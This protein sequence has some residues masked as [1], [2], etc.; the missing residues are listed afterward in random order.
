[1][2]KSSSTTTT[3]SIYTL[4]VL[5]ISV[6]LVILRCRI[7]SRQLHELSVLDDINTNNKKL[8]QAQFQEL[9]NDTYTHAKKKKNDKHHYHDYAIFIVY[10][11]KTGCVLS[12]KLKKLINEVDVTAHLSTGENEVKQKGRR[13]ENKVLIKKFSNSAKFEVSG[14]DDT[15]ERVAFDTLGNWEHSSFPKRQHIEG[16]NCP[17]PPDGYKR[18]AP[19]GIHSDRFE[20]KGGSL[21]IQ[22]S[23]DIFCSDDDLLSAMSTKGTKIVHF[24]RN[25][26]EM[27]MSNY[28]YHSQDPTPEKWVHTDEPCQHLYKNKE[29]LS[30]HV[31]PTLSTW[32]SNRTLTVPKVTQTDLHDIVDMCKSLFQ[33]NHTLKDA[34]FY[35]HLLKLDQSDALRLATAQMT[36]ASGAANKHSAGGDILRMTNNIIRF[37]NLQASSSNVQVMSLGMGDFITDT[38][39]ATLKF[40]N[41]IFGDDEK[42]TYEMRLQAATDRAKA[43]E[44]QSKHSHHITSA[45][46]KV[47][48]SKEVLRQMLKRDKHLG[49]ILNLTE[50]LVN[51][52]LSK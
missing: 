31:M 32:M 1:M 43:Y 11:H 14:I 41:F 35:E 22:A 34:S 13:H 36:I 5:T 30:S 9:F 8:L 21:Y 45:N 24:I 3:R 26:F 49:S 7:R 40:L 18:Q 6:L 47:A 23:P 17:K 50:I 19:L 12:H 38:K 51:E 28:F 15:G 2:M 46:S 27:T 37:Q 25:P 20:L 29:S 48:E 4:L 33:T 42:I 52:A 10:Y 39:E 44:K 16:Y